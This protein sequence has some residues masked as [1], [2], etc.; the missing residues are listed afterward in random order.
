MSAVIGFGA[1]IIWTGQGT[2]LVLNSDKTTINRN[3]GIF[4]AMLQCRFVNLDFIHMVDVMDTLKD[5]K[6]K[7][8]DYALMRD[9]FY[10]VF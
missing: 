5:K 2:Y 4:W 7:N 3:S 1:A 9:V 8:Y 10:Y 6:I